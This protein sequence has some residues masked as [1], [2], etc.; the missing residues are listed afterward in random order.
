LKDC[1][2]CGAWLPLADFY[3]HPQMAD[4][5]LN[6]CKA[7]VRARVTGQRR[8]DLAVRA[9]D[10]E[11]SRTPARQARFR[12]LSSRLRAKDPERYRRMRAAHSA[13]AHALRAGR[14]IR[15][16][17]C[18]ACGAHE[19]LH[20]AHADY[21]RPLDVRWLCRSCHGRWDASEPKP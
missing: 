16:A 14:L 2:G 5:H 21:A 12:T 8:T 7:C 1:Y 9:R 13:V 10:L 19:P 3:A 11:R 4:G 17:S 20:A 6:Y 18:T 15:P